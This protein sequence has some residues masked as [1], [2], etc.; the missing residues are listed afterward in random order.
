MSDEQ[1]TEIQP[2]ENERVFTAVEQEAMAQGW[3]PKEEFEGDPDRFIDAGEFVRRGELFSKIDHQ[4]KELK[5]L[6]QAM[7]QFKAHHAQVDQ[8]AYE[9]AVADLKRQRKE[10]LAEGDVDQ[11]DQLDNAIDNLK[12]QREA[13]LI[14]QAQQAHQQAQQVDPAFTEWVNKNPWYTTD[15]TMAGAAN[16]YGMTLAKQGVPPL[17]VLKRVEQHIKQE[18]KHKFTNPNREK[19]S[20]VESPGTRGSGAKT[21]YQPSEMEKRIGASLVRAKAFEKVEDYYAELEKM[22]GKN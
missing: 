9:R 16:A 5:Q 6:R 22:N 14:R 2:V 20:A 3:R 7:E 8:R 21:K 11:Y 18:F 15:V 19:P 1:N 12:E 4:N 17:E 13:E 10:A